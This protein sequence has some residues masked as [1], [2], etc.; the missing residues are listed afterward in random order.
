M[1]NQVFT[2]NG[3]AVAGPGGLAHL[4]ADP[5]APNAVALGETISIMAPG[6]LGQ[7]SVTLTLP[8]ADYSA[9][10]SLFIV[11][12]APGDV[13]TTY[14]VPLEADS[15]VIELGLEGEV[16]GAATLTGAEYELFIVDTAGRMGTSLGVKAVDYDAIEAFV[17]NAN[18]VLTGTPVEGAA[19]T[20]T[21]LD[22]VG[23]ESVIISYVYQMTEDTSSTSP[24]TEFDATGIVPNIAGAKDCF[25]VGAY[26]NG[27]GTSNPSG[28]YWSASV[29][30]TAADAPVA[31]TQ[32]TAAIVASN[33]IAIDTRTGVLPV[34]GGTLTSGA[35]TATIVAYVANT[36]T[37]GTLYTGAITGGTI[38]D[39][40]VLTWTA[41]AALANGASAAWQ[42][43][44]GESYYILPGTY[45][46]SVTSIIVRQE[47]A[48]DSAGT[49]AALV[50]LSGSI[51]AYYGT[52]YYRYTQRVSGY[53]IATY[54]DYTTGWLPIGI[55]TLSA[56]ADSEWPTITVSDVT[57]GDQ[58]E[59]IYLLAGLG[60]TE[61][62]W[63]TSSDA[64]IDANPYPAGFEPMTLLGTTTVGAIVY[65]RWQAADAIYSG[66]NYRVFGTTDTTRRTRLRIVA[67]I[68]GARTPLSNPKTVP[69]AGS[70]VVASD[71]ARFIN[72]SQQQEREG[73]A[74][75][76]GMQFPRGFDIDGEYV[77]VSYD[78][79]GPS[80]S[81]NWGAD[82]NVDPGIG[83][84]SGISTT[85][86]CIDGDRVHGMFGALFMRQ[87]GNHDNYEGIYTKSRATGVWDLKKALTPVYGSNGGGMR[88]NQRSIAMVAGSGSGPS[89]RTLFAMHAPSTDGSATTIQIY[90][91]T[92]GGSSW[93]TD[94]GTLATS[95]YSQPLT[96]WAD[97]TALYMTTK[98]G[99]YRRAFA[100]T[101][102]TKATGL[103]AGAVTWL[104][105]IGSTV[106]MSVA[107]VGLYTAPD[108]TTLAVTLKKSHDCRVF[109]VCPTNTNRI[110]IAGSGE[111]A[112]FTLNANAATPTWGTVGCQKYPGQPNPSA[113]K[114]SGP[115]SWVRWHDTDPDRFI[116]M[117]AQHMGV[118]SV[119][120][121]AVTCYWGSNNQDYSETRSI[122]FHRTDYQRMMIGMTDRLIT[123][124]D[125]GA[126]FVTDDAITDADK[127]TIKANVGNPSLSA[128]SA[129]GGVVLDRGTRTGYVS[130]M[131]DYTGAKTPV[132]LGR[133]V[134]TD[135][136]DTAA[137][138]NGS[139]SVTASA[140]L[141]SGEYVLTCTTAAAN[142][143][144][145][146][147]VGPV[148]VSLGTW[149]VG[150]ARTYTHPRGGTLAVTISDG[151][152]D[153]KAGTTP[154]IITVTVN[155][156]GGTRTILN[157]A[158]KDTCVFGRVNPAVG[159][160]G[161]SGKHVFEMATDGSISL[162]T[163]LSQAFVGFLGTTGNV[164]LGYSGAAT[165]YRGTSTNGGQTYAFSSWSTGI[166][167][168]S[169][170]GTPVVVASSHDD[171]RAWVGLGKGRVQKIQGS[172]GTPTKTTIFDFDAWCTLNGITSSVV[173][174]NQ[175][176]GRW[177]PSVAGV[178]ESFYDPNLVYC[179]CYTFGASLLFFRTKN[180][181]DATPDW[182]NITLDGAGRG[183]MQPIQ[184]MNIHPLTDEVFMYSSHGLVMHRP[185]ESHRTT[186]SITDSLIDDL[187]AGP[188]GDYHITS[189]I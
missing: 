146:T 184:G 40:A 129:R 135:R 81:F 147:G 47:I 58:L 7:R 33:R 145:F 112:S 115:P 110:I 65:Q 4:V 177:V 154:G 162:I 188:G 52:K 9:Y 163:T 15:T 76:A 141:P 148:G 133:S 98:N 186:Y 51:P 137:T 167:N 50:D 10:S 79:T 2:R 136:T 94:G 8:P 171:E 172:G 181:L 17:V 161:I 83:L 187:R 160:R 178:A 38:A 86:I 44:A 121:S 143:G 11:W 92:N 113:H 75:G 173:G 37:T 118:G 180:A 12:R 90:K 46:G 124:T 34:A 139:I 39:N 93:A 164:I 95:T 170:R 82:W 63:T 150:T 176:N 155:P 31:V 28:P 97:G 107:T 168:F 153:W 53:G 35:A 99:C 72:R 71:R 151:S 138:G 100:G 59:E 70:P 156:V 158:T 56:L 125:H 122:A 19:V 43:T 91:S 41:G 77:Q 152:V 60:A 26:A 144:T 105:K 169:G 166:D 1:A 104:E 131:G 165:L 127:T 84:Y 134:T 175:I 85:G 114:L 22:W 149:A 66:K 27:P 120:G 159:Y 16:L 54:T 29:S 189:K 69:T 49:G 142:G 111:P 106:Y 117:R 126:M 185:E 80:E 42:I 32:T 45:A 132:I 88:Y 67:I 13:S 96:L 116:C 20:F 108:A 68:G 64:S 109:S 61:V 174:A 6:G 25:R 123:G 103:A 23:D 179:A 183:L 21:P 55:P 62:R 102:W 78:V 30:I 14:S 140:D 36:S 74:G 157:P 18:P 3:L 57:D 119:N 89:T 87:Q 128:L 101:T 130:Q 48:T 73:T 24:G 5:L 182:E